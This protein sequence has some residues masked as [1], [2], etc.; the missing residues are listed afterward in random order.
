MTIK[1]QYFSDLHL[2]F[3]EPNKIRKIYKNIIPNAEICV[4]A[5]DIGLPF[6]QSYTDFLIYMNNIFKH[7]FL[8]TG[9]HEYYQIKENSNKTIEEINNKINEIILSNN[10][11]NIHFLNNSS[12]DLNN[13]R[14]IGTTLWSK[15]FLPKYTV[16]DKINIHNF[17][18]ENNNKLFNENY[19]FIEEEIK[20][21][22]IDN[23]KLIVITHHV[24][25]FNLIN[26][27]YKTGYMSLYNQCFAS[28][29]DSLIKEP[30][31]CWIY[32]HTHMKDSNKINNIDCLVNP[33]GYPG[34]NNSTDFNKIIEY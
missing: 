2:E 11:N 18:V 27:K 31:L 4:L 15:I 21:A 10:L 33:I 5:G 25:S 26:D 17:S 20:K 7:I 19:E 14:F 8:I 24:P 12:F 32:G 6:Q 34:E 13:Y 9:N 1:I 29:C 3:I 22:E 28:Q 23:K 30:I 16:N